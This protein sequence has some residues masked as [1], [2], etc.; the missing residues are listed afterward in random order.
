MTS[1]TSALAVDIAEEL[2][3]AQALANRIKTIGGSVPGSLALKMTQSALQ[4]PADT[5][6]VLSVI[7]GVIAA[8]ESAIAGYEELIRICDGVD[9]VTQDLAVTNLGD[10]QEHLREF[11]GFLREYEARRSR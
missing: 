6:D 5:T 11:L 9:Y 2:A 7:K 10:E 1:R 3:H 8:E 4:P